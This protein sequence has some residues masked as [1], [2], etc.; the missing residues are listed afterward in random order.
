MDWGGGRYQKRDTEGRC[1]AVAARVAGRTAH[2]H[3][4]AC[5]ISDARAGC[6][7]L[8]RQWFHFRPE[9][10]AACV[11]IAC[12][13]GDDLD[14]KDGHTM[15]DRGAKQHPPRNC[16]AWC[17]RT[18]ARTG[19]FG[20]TALSVVLNT[21]SH[22]PWFTCRACGNSEVHLVHRT[23]RTHLS[24]SRWGW[25]GNTLHLFHGDT[26]ISGSLTQYSGGGL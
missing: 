19:P 1:V 8:S 18:T 26:Y 11:A 12:H 21:P 7:G 20:S 25:G 23:S 22:S 9:D 17:D 24:A 15:T 3:S 13:C 4:G 10:R 2:W 14:T 5:A 6:A 16:T